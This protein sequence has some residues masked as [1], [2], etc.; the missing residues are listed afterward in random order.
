[1]KTIICL[2]TGE[3]KRIKYKE[4]PNEALEKITKLGGLK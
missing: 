3:I 4:I 1:M 2:K